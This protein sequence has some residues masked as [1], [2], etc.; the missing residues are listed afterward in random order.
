M[1]S[2]ALAETEFFDFTSPDV[3][4]FVAVHTADVGPGKKEQAIALFYA[5]RD[6]LHYEIY[7]ADFAPKDMRASAVLQKGAGLCIHKSVVYAATL[8]SI[9]V[10]ARLWLTDVRNHLCSDQLAKLMGDRT[11]HYHCLVSLQ[12]DNK[13]VR[14]TPV[15]NKRL[16][17]L[18][19]MAP[20]D[21]DGESDCVH[22]PFD[23][24]GLQ[25]M[26]LIRDHGEFEDLPYAMVLA[27]LRD[28]HA[29]LFASP[30]KFHS[31]SLRRDA[32]LS[33]LAR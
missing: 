6:R 13:W 3:R 19:N 25:H 12:L 7:N 30:T 22:H 20:L 21:F 15:F 32:K 24:T 33:S 18:F 27:G 11:F 29:S 14:A 28:K 26:E 16:C 23:D 5:V 4:R 2:S 9:G 8:R 31:G 10:P 1:T 17:Q